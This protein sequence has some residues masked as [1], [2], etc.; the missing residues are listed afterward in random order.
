MTQET[1]WDTREGLED[2]AGPGEPGATTT[3]RLRL[4]PLGA[5]LLSFSTVGTIQTGLRIYET[6]FMAQAIRFHGVV[7]PP[8]ESAEPFPSNEKI[9]WMLG[10]LS[11]DDKAVMAEELLRAG[12]VACRAH[13]VSPLAAA[14]RSWEATAEELADREQPETIADARND[15]EP[16][17]TIEELTR[18]LRD[19]A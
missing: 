12:V 18:R 11:S 19:L 2:V 3:G 17:L 6:S 7:G 8:S 16:P 15:D 9:S 5:N 13:D 1:F 14:I 4:E 10:A